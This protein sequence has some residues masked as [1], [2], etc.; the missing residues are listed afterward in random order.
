MIL[1]YVQPCSAVIRK[2][3]S[4]VFE[5][6]AFWHNICQKGLRRNF[7]FITVAFSSF[8]YWFSNML[9]LGG[10]IEYTLYCLPSELHTTFIQISYISYQLQVRLG[11]LWFFPFCLINASCQTVSVIY[12]VFLIQF[13]QHFWLLTG[14]TVLL[15]AF[16]APGRLNINYWMKV[17]NHFRSLHRRPSSHRRCLRESHQFVV[18]ASPL[19]SASC[20]PLHPMSYFTRMINVF[21]W[22]FSTRFSR[23]LSF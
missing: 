8:I 1:N 13:S 10:S 17:L 16:I 7:H 6:S 5:V 4:R 23:C 19:C 21:Y 2:M 9:P 20:L 3:L 22:S 11:S 15:F 18:Q 14:A 12:A